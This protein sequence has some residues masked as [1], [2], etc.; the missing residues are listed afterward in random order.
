M[1]TPIVALTVL[2]ATAFY[3][4]I[5]VLAHLLG[6]KERPGG[7]YER[8]MRGWA[9]SV[10]AAAGIRVHLHGAEHI[11]TRNGAVYIANHVSWFDVFALAAVL[12]RYTFIAKSE[13]RR[14]P[15]FGQA[16]ERAGIVFID[17]DNRKSAFESYRRAAADVQR[18]RSIIVCPEGTRGHDYHLRPFKK[19][20]F[21]LAIASQSPVVPTI[22]YGAREV[23]PKGTFR[24]K[25]GDVH[26]HLLEPVATVGYDYEH[27]GGLM[28]QVWTRMAE[29]L[30]DLYGVGT[31][32]QS[33][34]VEQ[35]QTQSS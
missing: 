13:L 22:V 7:I 30:R 17:R 3:G 25:S 33:L 27:R 15:L 23:M 18:G 9:R 2:V 11:P 31:S 26:V 6:I 19:G 8:C 35:E 16:A 12:P 10:N 21:V 5:V 34:A 29:A 28:T 4:P 24:I 32:E 20:P 14:I 1:R